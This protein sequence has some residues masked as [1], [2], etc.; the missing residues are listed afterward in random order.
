MS[1]SRQAVLAGRSSA[2]V[3]RVCPRRRSTPASAASPAS[4]KPAPDSGSGTQDFTPYVMGETCLHTYHE[5]NRVCIA[6][7]T[8]FFQND[9]FISTQPNPP[10]RASGTCIAM[11]KMRGFS[12]KTTPSF[13]PSAPR[14]T[15]THSRAR[16]RG[17]G[18]ARL[19]RRKAWRAEDAPKRAGC[20]EC[21]PGPMPRRAAHLQELPA[22]PEAARSA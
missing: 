21:T 9:P 3:S 17:F 2:F 5:W 19:F 6:C 15:H 22:L 12:A 10:F 8:L 13:A 1:C 11:D 18:T 14:G 4:S 7:E 16:R 20:A